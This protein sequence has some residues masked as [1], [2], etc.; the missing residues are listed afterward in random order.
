[1]ER[2]CA[3]AR[4][5]DINSKVRSL[6]RGTCVWARIVNIPH[7]LKAGSAVTGR[8]NDHVTIIL[9]IYTYIYNS[10]ILY[11]LYRYIL[12]TGII[13]VRFPRFSLELG[14]LIYIYIYIYIFVCI[15]IYL[16]YNT[17]WMVRA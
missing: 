1:M 4:G 2:S 15:Y 12:F 9:Y 6:G 3:V 11:I 7:Y 14:G 16:I 17:L 13:S 5:K 8:R 10:Y